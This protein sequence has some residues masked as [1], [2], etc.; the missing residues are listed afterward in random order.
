MTS[1]HD[2]KSLSNVELLVLARGAPKS[3]VSDADL[4]S[5]VA[6]YAPGEKQSAQEALAV[7]RRRSLVAASARTLTAAGRSALCAALNIDDAPSWQAVKSTCL[8]VLGFEQPRTTRA[9]SGRSKRTTIDARMLAAVGQRLQI[10]NVG[11]LSALCDVLLARALGFSGKVTLPALHAHVLAR[12]LGVD[13]ALASKMTREE[14]ASHATSVP[15]N[16]SGNGKRSTQGALG[17]PGAERNVATTE[18]S[19]PT[20]SISGAGRV[21]PPAPLN[22]VPADMLLDIVREAIPRIGSNG[23]FGPEKVFVSALW[24]YLEDDGRV[25]ELSLERFKRWLVTANRDQLVDLVRAD[26]QGDMDGRLLEESEI[27]DL[28]ATFHFVIDRQIAAS[29]RGYHAR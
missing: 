25:P 16:D 13:P 5:V 8:A 9:S 18:R 12:S 3:G 29:R 11:S 24:R 20:I 26:S 28:G 2:H 6:S 7:L 15:R 4:T 19:H 14:V 22:I 1:N 17:L 23:R 21:T 10:S 27:R